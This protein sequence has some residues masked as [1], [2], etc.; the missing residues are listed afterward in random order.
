MKATN[1]PRTFSGNELT[2]TAE[3][4]AGTRMRSTGD[5]PIAL[6]AS[7]PSSVNSRENFNNAISVSPVSMTRTTELL[8]RSVSFSTRKQK[9]IIKTMPAR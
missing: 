5:L 3:N 2:F 8:S 6:S 4:I 1:F 9:I 7:L